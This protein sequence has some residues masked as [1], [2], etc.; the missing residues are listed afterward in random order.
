MAM[1]TGSDRTGITFSDASG[2]ELDYSTARD[3]RLSVQEPQLSLREAE[4]SE[5][6]RQ[7]GVTYQRCGGGR[8]VIRRSFA[9]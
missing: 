8:R 4:D 7:C 2:A 9:R 1:F 6:A 3:C 5:Y